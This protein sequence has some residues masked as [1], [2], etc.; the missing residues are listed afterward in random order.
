MKENQP[1][2]AM[3]IA[4]IVGVSRS[5]VSKVINNYPNISAETRA[6]ILKAI[7]VHGYRPNLSARTLA[8]KKTE[9]LGFFFFGRDQFSS[10]PLVNAMIAIVIESAAKVGYHILTYILSSPDDAATRAM[11]KDVFSQGR[12][13]AGIILGARE[14]EPL[15]EELVTS[16]FVLGVFDQSVARHTEPNRLLA[17]LEDFET[18]AK[19]VRYLHG[20]GHRSVGILNGDLRRNAGWAKNA[21]FRQA[22]GE[23]GI[24]CRP[25]WVVSSDFSEEGAYQVVKAAAPGWK[26]SGP[27]AFVAANDP[28]AFGA[29][30]A[31]GELGIAVPGDVSLVGIDNH[32]FSGYVQPALTTFSYDFHQVFRDLIERVVAAVEGRGASV[33]KD[34]SFPSVLVERQSCR[35]MGR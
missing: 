35:V 27:T 23:C 10:D 31:F 15:V 22:L 13:D 26:H 11:V 21:G 3:A 12:V 6:V 1:V 24:E 34:M 5:T 14:D 19:A 2:D 33:A 7:E 16:G 30:R 9:T 28:I 18:A 8:G 4:R 32:P 29:L 17:N 20:L 25:S